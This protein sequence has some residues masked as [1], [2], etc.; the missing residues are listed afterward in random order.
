MRQQPGEGITLLGKRGIDLGGNEYDELVIT[1]MIPHHFG[2]GVSY[3]SFG[4]WL[5]FPEHHI[6]DVADWNN[7]FYLNRSKA[8]EEIKEFRGGL[9][10][11]KPVDRLLKVLD[12][13]RNYLTLTQAQENKHTLQESRES[14]FSF[15]CLDEDHGV[16]LFQEEYRECCHPIDERILRCARELTGEFLDRP[17]ELDTLVF[18]G[19]SSKLANL[20]NVFGEG[21]PAA[22]ILFDE[23]FFNS[24]SHGLALYA[25][26][27]NLLR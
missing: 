2:K 7:V 18:T 22:E 13:K 10:R 5:P 9:D 17:E 4:K 11:R 25:H 3:K 14:T 1:K 16:P 26:D 23:N 20:K 27:A 8:V 19:G 24:I 15:A 6:Y 21:Y 12:K